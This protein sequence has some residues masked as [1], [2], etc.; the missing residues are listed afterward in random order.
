MWLSPLTNTNYSHALRSYNTP[1]LNI[2]AAQLRTIKTISKIFYFHKNFSSSF[3]SKF[4]LEYSF[5]MKILLYIL[6][7]R[8]TRITL[9]RN[10]L[11]VF[12]STRKVA[13]AEDEG[14]IDQSSMKYL[15]LACSSEHR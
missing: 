14:N 12:L 1:S 9:I 13:V 3:K 5:L 8:Y 10:K 4:S 7:F 11:F 6:R 2:S 15:V